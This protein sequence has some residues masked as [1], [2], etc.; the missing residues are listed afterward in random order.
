MVAPFV[1]IR[2]LSKS[3]PGVVALLDVDIDIAAAEIVGL[4]GK[5]GAGKSTLIKVLAGAE[6]ADRG[7]IRV[8]DVLIPDRYDPSTAHRLGLA[9][10]HQELGNVPD[11]TVAENVALGG[12]YP[13]RAR[14]RVSW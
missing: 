10:M 8:D 6:S 14:A 13:R 4:V 3:Y 7:E 2:G 9:F 11:L 1:S 12:H 5:N